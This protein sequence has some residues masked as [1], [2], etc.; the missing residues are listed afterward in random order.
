MNELSRFLLD[1][2]VIPFIRIANPPL[3]I[4]ATARRWRA[5]AKFIERMMET[6][7]RHCERLPGT[8]AS[9]Y[10]C[11]E[12]FRPVSVICTFCAGLPPSDL[13]W[14]ALDTEPARSKE[15]DVTAAASQ[16]TS[17]FLIKL[18]QSFFFLFLSRSL[19]F[20]A[21]ALASALLLAPHA[22][23][24]RSN[25][26]GRPFSSRSGPGMLPIRARND[27]LRG[28]SPLFT[29]AFSVPPVWAL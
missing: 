6:N 19:I 3:S 14:V 8:V 29:G 13:A 15:L 11:C 22:W 16:R 25:R 9:G 4:L 10:D 17:G 2:D 18:L 28:L 24:L 12:V 1:A 7:H 27:A 23:R 26:V 5:Y 21:F 20:A